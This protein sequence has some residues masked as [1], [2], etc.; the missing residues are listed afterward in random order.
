MGNQ[1]RRN[2]YTAWIRTRFSHRRFCGL[3][4]TV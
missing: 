2:A 1:T 4:K 3:L